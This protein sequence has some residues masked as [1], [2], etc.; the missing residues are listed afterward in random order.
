MRVYFPSFGRC[1]QVPFFI[2]RPH[3]GICSHN[4]PLA[5]KK[6]LIQN[7]PQYI[8]ENKRK[9]IKNYFTKNAILFILVNIMLNI[10]FT[11]SYLAISFIGVT[12][13]LFVI[14]VL[15]NVQ[16]KNITNLFLFNLAIADLGT[17]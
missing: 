10:I 9:N 1:V 17:V 7:I 13:N 3:F 2:Q 4:F 14:V 11:I 16:Q 6:S 8:K 12:G 15:R 5:P